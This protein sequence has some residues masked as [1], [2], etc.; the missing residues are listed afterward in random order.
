M[1]NSVHIS[2]KS[3]VRGLRKKNEQKIILISGKYLHDF[4]IALTYSLNGKKAKKVIDFLPLFQRYVKG[5]NLEYFAP[6]NFKKFNISPGSISWGKNEDV[7]FSAGSLL[8]PGK[9][10]INP[11]AILYVI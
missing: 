4:T 3:K 7:I 9:K 6:D 10:S 1:G 11:E 5:E 8:K 2:Q